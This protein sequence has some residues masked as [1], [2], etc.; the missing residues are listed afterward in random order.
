MYKLIGSVVAASLLAAA[1]GATAGDW[2]PAAIGQGLALGVDVTSIEVDGDIRI[3]P[4]IFVHSPAETDEETESAYMV[5]AFA[6][7]CARHVGGLLETSSYKVD[8]THMITSDQTSPP[9]PIPTNSLLHAAEEMIC[10]GRRD[11]AHL[12]RAIDFADAARNLM[13]A[14]TAR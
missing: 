6:L 5:G 10:Q 9:I 12:A 3:A 7:D 1:T 11:P 2:Q 8:G 4:V 13:A 14:K